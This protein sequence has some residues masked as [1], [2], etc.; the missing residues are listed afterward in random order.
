MVGN[1]YSKNY[2]E[3]E[4]NGDRNITLSIKEYPDKIKSYL[5]DIINNLKNV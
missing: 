4:N 5:K 1:F 3:Y 2:I